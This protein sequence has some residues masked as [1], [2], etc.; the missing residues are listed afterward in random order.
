MA[1]GIGVVGNFK[2]G[3]GSA[4]G[5][6]VLMPPLPEDHSG[7]DLGIRST[8]NQCRWLPDD[9]ILVGPA[10]LVEGWAETVRNT[11]DAVGMRHSAKKWL[12][13][14]CAARREWCYPPLTLLPQPQTAVGIV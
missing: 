3:R 1:A 12:E 14:G 2:S 10:P 13:D 11:L 4:D 5:S 8:G 7:L 9:S 6:K